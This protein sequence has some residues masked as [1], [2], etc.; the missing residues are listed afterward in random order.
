M[1]QPADGLL[2]TFRVEVTQ[3]VEVKL[4]ADKFDEAFMNEFRASFYRFDTIEEHAEHLAQLQARGVCDLDSYG[5]EF[6]EGYGPSKDMGISAKVIETDV[7]LIRLLAPS[8]R[9]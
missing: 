4:D 9:G 5:G 2:K 6:V 1:M 3:L 8:E 7:D